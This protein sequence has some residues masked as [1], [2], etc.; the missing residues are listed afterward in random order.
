[1]ERRERHRRHRQPLRA[2]RAQREDLHPQPGA[3]KAM[4]TV[5]A[6]PRI[7]LGMRYFCSLPCGTCTLAIVPKPDRHLRRCCVGM[8][9]VVALCVDVRRTA[10]LL[11]LLLRLRVV[12]M[13]S[14]QQHVR[15][16]GDRPGCL[17]RWH[18]RDHRPDALPVSH[19]CLTLLHS[20]VQKARRRPGSLLS[21]AT[22]KRSGQPSAN[23]RPTSALTGTYPRLCRS[24]V[25]SCS[26]AQAC[27]ASMTEEEVAEGRSFPAIERIR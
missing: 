6:Q 15:L 18:E 14:V 1:M 9:V 23:R 21:A 17:C 22:H 10:A 4:L 11:S 19:A 7:P 16:P 13:A 5:P 26:A 8:A 25:F 24:C 27:V 3:R 12:L 20:P 2:C